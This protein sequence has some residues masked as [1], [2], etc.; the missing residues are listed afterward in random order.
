MQPAEKCKTWLLPPVDLKGEIY[1]KN[2]EMAILGGCYCN[3][4]LRF[5][6][7]VVGVKN[8]CIE[9]KLTPQEKGY[10]CG[11]PVRMKYEQEQRD[12]YATEKKECIIDAKNHL[13]RINDAKC[14]K[15]THYY[16]CRFIKMSYDAVVYGDYGD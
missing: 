2:E 9:C 15:C 10:C 16:E 12:K 3:V 6:R 8:P 5:C 1:G 4:R 13:L 14:K 7:G 11:C